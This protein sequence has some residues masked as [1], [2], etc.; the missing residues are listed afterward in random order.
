MNTAEVGW[1]RNHVCLLRIPSQPIPWI[2]EITKQSK[3]EWQ[4]TA[5][6]HKWHSNRVNWLHVEPEFTDFFQ[7]FNNHQQ[8]LVDTEIEFCEI[9][10]GCSDRW[11]LHIWWHF[12]RTSF[13]NERET[14]RTS[15]CASVLVFTFRRPAF[16]WKMNNLHVFAHIVETWT[17]QCHR[18]GTES[19][20]MWH[21]NAE[22]VGWHKPLLKRMWE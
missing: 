20:K 16:C 11:R 22:G 3:M 6:G 17:R 18:K 13:F 10:L 14:L 1:W 8:I 9:A 15:D 2:H 12:W 19:I 4:R 21:R 5:Q 7:Q